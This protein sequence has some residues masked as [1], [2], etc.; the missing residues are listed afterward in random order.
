MPTWLAV[1]AGGAV[2][3]LARYLVGVAW[4]RPGVFPW[5][6]L[7]INVAGSLALGVFAGVASARGATTSTLTLALTVGLCGGFTTFSTFS[8]ETLALLERGEWQRA[9]AYVVASV[10]L[11]LLAAAAGASV[12]TAF[13]RARLLS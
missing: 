12:A 4:A 8:V 5:W 7:A 9:G 1:A 10:L 6:T 2:G 3:T 11:G 13:I